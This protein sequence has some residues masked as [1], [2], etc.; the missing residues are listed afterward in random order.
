[1]SNPYLKQN[2]RKQFRFDIATIG[3]LEAICEKKG[4]KHQ[5]DAIREA[6]AVLG[7]QVLTQDEFNA[8][9]LNKI[10]SVKEELK[11]SSQEEE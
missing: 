4:Y 8:A 7:G 10:D 2:I 9:M 1:M 6:I 11:S 5:S 3:V